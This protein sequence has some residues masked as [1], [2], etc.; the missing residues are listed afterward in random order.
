MYNKNKK[1]NFHQLTNEDQ[2]TLYNKKCKK[3]N[4]CHGTK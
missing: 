3:Q 1:I 4:V 2:V